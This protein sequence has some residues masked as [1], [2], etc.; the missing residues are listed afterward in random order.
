MESFLRTIAIV[1]ELIIIMGTIFTFFL[2]LRLAL[3]DLG[4]NPRYQPFLR[5]ALTTVWIMVMVFF[6]SH[7]ILFYPGGGNP[8]MS[9]R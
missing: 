3:S 8:L 4:L 9:S 5:L 2:G 1:I 7:L 6:V